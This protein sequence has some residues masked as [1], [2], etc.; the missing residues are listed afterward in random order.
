[1]GPDSMCVR[2]MSRM[3]LSG[4]LAACLDI[5]ECE[6]RSDGRLYTY[7]DARRSLSLSFPQLGRNWPEQTPGSRFPLG[8]VH[9]RGRRHT[10]FPSSR[11]VCPQQAIQ[12][13]LYA[14]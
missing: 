11:Q 14:I 9:Q 4:S 13:T 1:M 10:P 6:N 8:F 3:P 5:V 7:Y 12:R 2:S